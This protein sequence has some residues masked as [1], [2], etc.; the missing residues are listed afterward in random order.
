MDREIYSLDNRPDNLVEMRKTGTTSIAH[1]RDP[2]FVDTQEGVTE[3]HP[4][5]VDDWDG[6]YYV[7]YPADGSK[8]YSI[9]PS[10]VR[11]NYE[12]A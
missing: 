10:F 9:A 11:K 6:G 4:G 1:V 5:T 2:F 3:V 7:A 12:P 8:P